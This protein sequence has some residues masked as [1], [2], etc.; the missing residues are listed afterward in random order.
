MER[1][2]R[3][4]IIWFAVLAVILFTIDRTSDWAIR[5][6]AGWQIGMWGSKLYEWLNEKIDVKTTDE[7]N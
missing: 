1:T 2:I 4:I 6:I 7:K 3:R 5:V